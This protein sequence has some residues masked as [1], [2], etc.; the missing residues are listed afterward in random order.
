VGVVRPDFSVI[1]GLLKPLRK[2][3]Y[4]A[5]GVMGVLMNSSCLIKSA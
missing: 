3:V 1:A 4:A 5:G 2:S